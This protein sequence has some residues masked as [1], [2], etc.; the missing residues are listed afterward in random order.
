M[1]HQTSTAA[2]YT[3]AFGDP[4]EDARKDDDGS[5]EVSDEAEETK[6]ASAPAESEASVKDGGEEPSSGSEETTA[7][8][9]QAGEAEN[10]GGLGR[11][12][13]WALGGLGVI[14]LAGG[15]LV[16]ANRRHG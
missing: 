6:G 9:V 1:Q 3:E 4:E 14:A 13:P 12:L 10:S 8:D 15:G 5:A 11:I 2:Q 7:A 16:L